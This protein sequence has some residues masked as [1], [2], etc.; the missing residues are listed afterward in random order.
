MNIFTVES[1]RQMK[2]CRLRLT[3][4]VQRVISTQPNQPLFNTET[5]KELLY[6]LINRHKI[7]IGY[8]TTEK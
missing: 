2:L 4:S 1:V 7:Q 3:F 6:I 8:N 5:N